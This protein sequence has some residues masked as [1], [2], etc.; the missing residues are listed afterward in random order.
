MEILFN[1]TSFE[2]YSKLTDWKES[3]ARNFTA[4]DVWMPK[5]TDQLETNTFCEVLRICS[6]KVILVTK[7]KRARVSLRVFILSSTLIYLNMLF[8]NITIF[9]K[10]SM[11]SISSPNK[12]GPPKWA[13]FCF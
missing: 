2:N 9:I 7:N 4:W 3:S 11:S 1:P 12:K 5:L 13:S 10:S 8:D 6:S